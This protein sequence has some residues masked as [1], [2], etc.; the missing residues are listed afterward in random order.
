[1]EVA[2]IRELATSGGRAHAV[3]SGEALLGSL[4][5]VAGLFD[6][7]HG[8]TVRSARDVAAKTFRREAICSVLAVP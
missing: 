2:L 4:A 5:G 6:R 3:G 1:M 7:I 8:V